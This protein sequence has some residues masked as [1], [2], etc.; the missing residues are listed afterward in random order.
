VVEIGWTWYAPDAR[1]T[2]LNTE[3]KLLMLTHAF[4]IW[5]VHCVRL[6]TDARNERSRLAILRLGAQFDGIVHGHRVGADGTVRSIRSSTPSG[7]V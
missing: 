1:R 6:M 4:E 3:A 7:R 2:G 5:R